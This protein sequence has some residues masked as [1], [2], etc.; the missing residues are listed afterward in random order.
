[1]ELKDVTSITGNTC[2]APLLLQEMSEMVNEIDPTGLLNGSDNELEDMDQENS[3]GEAGDTHARVHKI[4]EDADSCHTLSPL[5]PQYGSVKERRILRSEFQKPS[6]TLGSGPGMTAN[7]TQESALLAPT[8]PG[9]QGPVFLPGTAA[10]GSTMFYSV[11]VGT[12]ATDATAAAAAPAASDVARAKVATPADTATDNTTDAG[13]A[14]SFSRGDAASEADNRV[15]TRNDYN[16]SGNT[17]TPTGNLTAYN[18]INSSCNAQSD[19]FQKI[20]L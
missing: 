10:A 17:G 20:L 15:P 8:D 3:T 1:M 19:S 9:I 13:T 11:P 2:Q 7:A 16:V 18:T 6:N 4:S 12:A 5:P 14:A